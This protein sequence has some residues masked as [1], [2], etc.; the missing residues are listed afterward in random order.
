[1]SAR[2]LC[3][4]VDAVVVKGAR[5][6]WCVGGCAVRQPQASGLRHVCSYVKT[7]SLTI[8][9]ATPRRHKQ[10]WGCRLQ[11]FLGVAAG[12]G[13][14]LARCVQPGGFATRGAQRH[15]G[16][17][18]GTRLLANSVQDT[19]PQSTPVTHRVDT[20]GSSPQVCCFAA[21][22]TH[23]YVSAR[24]LA[25]HASRLTG[26]LAGQ[27]CVWRGRGPHSTRNR[28]PPTHAC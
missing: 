16:G 18:R 27:A 10:Q 6:L 2:L 15:A 8:V 11:P 21:W 3:G 20:A 24:L 22:H 7:R 26:W 12:R 5:R 9:Q 25:P 4:A 1:M 23:S 28:S 17:A 14:S 19:A 13:Q